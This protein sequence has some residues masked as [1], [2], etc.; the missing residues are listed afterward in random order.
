MF[1]L[2]RRQDVIVRVRPP[3]L[4]Q[5]VPQCLAKEV[6]GSAAHKCVAA[7]SSAARILDV[8]GGAAALTVVGYARTSFMH[9]CTQGPLSVSTP[10][11]KSVAEPAAAVSR[12]R[13]LVQ[14]RPMPPRGCKKLVCLM[15]YYRASF[16]GLGYECVCSLC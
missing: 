14:Q 2:Q 11:P 16:H 15:C 13:S 12:L 10:S 9:C 6:L 4:P 5:I 1:V 7:T 3:R 8:L